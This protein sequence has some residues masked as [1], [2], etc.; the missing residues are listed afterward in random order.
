MK[1]WHAQN[2]P[3]VESSQ[4]ATKNP[5]WDLQKITMVKHSKYPEGDML[6][7][8]P[9]VERSQNIQMV[10]H[11]KKCPE[12]DTSQKAPAGPFPKPQCRELQ[13]T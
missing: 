13:K 3:G 1:W 10:K 7:K 11:L 2:S 6:P 5:G 8:T 12:V 4:K 9:G